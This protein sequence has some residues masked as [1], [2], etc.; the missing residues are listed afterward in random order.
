MLG[1]GIALANE[2][3]R[4]SQGINLYD[5][6]LLAVIH[7]AHGRIAQMQTGEGKTFVAIAAAAHF[8]LAG[9]GVHV[10]TPNSYL[11]SRDF[12]LAKS[13]LQPLG[14]TVGLT[15]EQGET[16]VK[17]AAYDCDVIYGTGH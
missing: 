1:A 8:A 6:Q 4:R 11:A 13:V 2:A 15:P 3:L 5:V 7:L 9:K 12:E 16:D 17:R 14:M 10:M